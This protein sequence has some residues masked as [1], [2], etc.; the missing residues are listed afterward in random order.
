MCLEQNR[1]RILDTSETL[2]LELVLWI[3]QSKFLKGTTLFVSYADWS[4]AIPRILGSVMPVS[5]GTLKSSTGVV[6]RSVWLM[7]VLLWRYHFCGPLGGAVLIRDGTERI[8]NIKFLLGLITD[9]ACGPVLVALG[10]ENRQREN[11]RTN[12]NFYYST[13]K[14]VQG[15]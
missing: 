12:T 13:D 2:P 5:W 3:N 10:E 11:H 14:P 4:D 8:P 15:L 9:I 6:Y 7:R 1:H